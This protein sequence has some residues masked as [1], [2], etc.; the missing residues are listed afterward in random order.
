MV[1]CALCTCIVISEFVKSGISVILR[2]YGIA[3]VDPDSCHKEA[4]SLS[5]HR[6][7]V[8]PVTL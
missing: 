1:D 5:F 4:F 8:N 7:K 6:A 2:L 3:K